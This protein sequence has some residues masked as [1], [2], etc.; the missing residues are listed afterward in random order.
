MFD[1]Q[2]D[3][4]LCTDTTLLLDGYPIGT[5]GSCSWWIPLDENRGIKVFTE[6]PYT[7]RQAQ[8]Q[9][10][11]SR[12][13]WE[14]FKNQAGAAD[15]YLPVVYKWWVIQH[16]GW[17][18]D[19]DIF[20][21]YTGNLGYHDKDTCFVAA[22][23]KVYECIHRRRLSDDE[24]ETMQSSFQASGI[25]PAKDCRGYRQIGEDDVSIRLLDVTTSDGVKYL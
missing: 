24:W 20:S 8:K 14:A 7:L 9:K 21:N 13:R 10:A 15:R 3:I 25:S 6:F 12:A 5:F 17:R 19:Y 18:D 2:G 1:I 22:V 4:R 23:C 11:M 16:T